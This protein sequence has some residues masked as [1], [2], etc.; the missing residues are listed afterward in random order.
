[1]FWRSCFS[2]LLSNRY[3]HSHQ[4]FHDKNHPPR[5]IYKGNPSLTKF[6]QRLVRIRD[7]S[8]NVYSTVSFSFSAMKRANWYVCAI[9]PSVGEKKLEDLRCIVSLVCSSFVIIRTWSQRFIL[10]LLQLQM[11][12]TSE[13]WWNTHSCV[14]RWRK[15]LVSRRYLYIGSVTPQGPHLWN[16]LYP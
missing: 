15:W 4:T 7:S 6:N 16:L 5:S 3:K 10:N 12:I 2:S 9:N 1:M 14:S 8:F 13:H 11:G